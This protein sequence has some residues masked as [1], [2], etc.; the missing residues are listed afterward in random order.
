MNKIIKNF[1]YTLTSNIIAFLI[2]ALVTF[3][4]PKVLGVENYSYFQLYLFYVSYTG[5]LHFGWA[6]G[7]YLR[8]GGKYYEELDRKNSAGSSEHIV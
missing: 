8:Y 5:F 2:S 3:I 7:I 4:V 1:S 6:D